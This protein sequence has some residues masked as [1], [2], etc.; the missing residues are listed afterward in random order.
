MVR[1]IQ[2]E[3]QILGGCQGGT[4]VLFGRTGISR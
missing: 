4:D 2:R 1:I 3:D